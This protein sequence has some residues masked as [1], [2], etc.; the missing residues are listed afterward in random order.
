[1]HTVKSPDAVPWWLAVSALVV[2]RFDR[3]EGAEHTDWP[4][5]TYMGA[6]E[7]TGVP[8]SRT[9]H[10]QGPSDIDGF[11]LSRAD[12][13]M[14]CMPAC[15]RES[16][17]GRQQYLERDSGARAASPIIRSSR[18]SDFPKCYLSLTAE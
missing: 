3:S 9:A 12:R 2:F 18:T 13:A 6:Y 4:S 5:M 11:Q 16:Q 7:E 14:R 10:S 1:M 8:L 17:S 15:L